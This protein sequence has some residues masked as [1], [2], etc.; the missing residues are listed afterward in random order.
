MSR[1]LTWRL[2]HRPN[3]ATIH[4][5]APS[6]QALEERFSASA[7]SV[8]LPLGLSI[9]RAASQA[10]Q[11]AST[12]SAEMRPVAREQDGAATEKTELLSLLTFSSAQADKTETPTTRGTTAPSEWS[13]PPSSRTAED[14]PV[15]DTLFAK[16]PLRILSSP[17]SNT[18]AGNG[19]GSGS[20]GSGPGGS[21]TPNAGMGAGGSTGGGGG[22]GLVNANQFMTANLGQQGNSSAARAAE[23]PGFSFQSA[24]FSPASTGHAAGGA[25]G[26][27]D[28][29]ATPPATAASANPSPPHGKPTTPQGPAGADPLYV[30]DLNT[31][32]TLPANATLLSIPKASEDL[33]A[34]VS[35]ATVSSYS[36]NLTQAPD[37]LGVSGTNTYNLQGTWSQ[38]A[39]GN[40][41]TISVTETPTSGSPL[42]VTFSFQLTGAVARPTTSSTWSNVLTPV[43][44]TEI[45][46]TFLLKIG[47]GIASAFAG[48]PAERE[49]VC[50]SIPPVRTP[51]KKLGGAALP[52][53]RARF[54]AASTS[55]VPTPRPRLRMAA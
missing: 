53:A 47:R 44:L 9:G 34:Q 4:Y 11:V 8:G 30:V 7:L 29:L 3:R 42:T 26:T 40:T 32:E 39:G 27:S 48:R 1:W 54:R 5:S 23:A 52:R 16:L 14:R 28:P 33:I 35:G 31:G 17:P 55:T 21:S 46:V 19:A 12:T 13:S 49:V 24:L 38:L 36:W 51:C 6:L 41:D 37:L 18:S 50:L 2:R 43:P 10:D 45:G 15:L 25:A 20:G 22:P